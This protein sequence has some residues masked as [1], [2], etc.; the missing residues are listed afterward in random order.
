MSNE[1]VISAQHGKY[2]MKT[3]GFKI[4]QQELASVFTGTDEFIPIV[5]ICFVLTV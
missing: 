5:Q 4:W 3:S 2:G 1:G